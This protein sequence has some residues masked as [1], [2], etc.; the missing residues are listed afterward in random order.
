MCDGSQD[1]AA[2][3]A[4]ASRGPQSSFRRIVRQADPA[5][6]DESGK[7]IPASLALRKHLPSAVN[8]AFAR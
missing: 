3:W 8:D 6:V 7:P 1:Q 5:I 2:C 4:R